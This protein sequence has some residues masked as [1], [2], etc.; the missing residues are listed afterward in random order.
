MDC[1]KFVQGI[2]EAGD[3]F[4]MAAGNFESR[5]VWCSAGLSMALNENR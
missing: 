1:I 5:A 2:T 3:N 4:Q